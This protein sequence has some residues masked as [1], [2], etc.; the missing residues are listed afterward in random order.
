M[1]SSALTPFV[2]S[3]IV[4]DPFWD[5][6]SMLTGN[7]LGFPRNITSQ[8]GF[9]SRL[10]S[11]VGFPAISNQNLGMDLTEEAD[12]WVVHA[13]L[14]GFKDEDVELTIENGMLGVRATREKTEESDTG[15]SHRVEVETRH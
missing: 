6:D 12:Q 10:G 15:I 2:T 7:T 14:P 4:D 5:M 3:S 1:M 8:F 11:Q 9:P 13:D